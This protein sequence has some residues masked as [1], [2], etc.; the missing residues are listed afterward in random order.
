MKKLLRRITLAVVVSLI[1]I[2]CVFQL[3]SLDSTSEMDTVTSQTQTVESQEFFELLNLDEATEGNY[4]S[5]VDENDHRIMRTARHIHVGD[6]YICGKNKLYEVHSVVDYTAHAREIER[7]QAGS[8]FFSDFISSVGERLNFNIPV[9]LQSQEAQQE[10]RLLGVYHSHGAEAYVP[11]DGEE[12]IDEGGG[13]LDV[14]RSLAQ[15]LE[16]KGIEVIHSEET[17]VPHDSGAYVRSRR[18]AEEMLQED[19]DALFDVHRDAVPPD[20]YLAEVEGEERVQIQL[21]VG[22]QN[23]NASNIQQF[24]EGLKEK[25]DELYPNLVKGIF[26]AQGNYNQDMSPNA[27]LLEVGAHENEKAG[28]QESVVLFADVI[29]KYLYGTDEGG[30]QIGLTQDSPGG[31]GGTAIT[32]VFSLLALVVAAL[33]AYLLIST[34]NLEEA[35]AKLKHF[36]SKEFRDIAGG[37]IKQKFNNQEN[38]EFAEEISPEDSSSSEENDPEEGEKDSQE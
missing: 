5:M 23:Q 31:P 16:D 34:E 20:E 7:T 12:S 36:T 10:N 27:M 2:V 3:L 18:T 24:A 1:I 17:H 21:I 4:Y 8:S 25:G 11:G 32:Q 28:A 29:S 15:A 9:L 30:E 22:R 6:Q 14:G 33:A 37:K 13:I 26:M 35:K 19:P 38:T